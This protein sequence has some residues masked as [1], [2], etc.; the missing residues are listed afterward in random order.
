M[1]E[2]P[3]DAPGPAAST[4][5]GISEHRRA[6]ARRH[7]GPRRLRRGGGRRAR[8]RHAART[9]STGPSARCSATST[10][11]GCRPRCCRSRPTGSPSS[12]ASSPTARS[13]A[14]RP[15]TCSPSACSEPKRPKQVVEE[16][17][18]AQVSDEGELGARRRRRCSPRTPTS[19]EEYRA[20]DDKVR[21]KKR[22]FLMGE[23]DAG[24]S[25]ARGTRRSSTS[26]LD[27]SS[28]PDNRHT[29]AISLPDDGR[30]AKRSAT[31]G[32]ATR[33]R[34]STSAGRGT[35][36]FRGRPTSSIT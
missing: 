22:G 14:A 25:R 27:R 28:P 18:L 29:P 15:R 7:A 11:P 24:D 31:N 5:W 8:R 23:V 17:G 20:G 26:L 10:R 35:Q 9:S 19:V 3:A 4:E 2:L 34:S 1:P 13:R 30:R 21:K 16:R 12:S 32:A 36:A 6:G 33:P